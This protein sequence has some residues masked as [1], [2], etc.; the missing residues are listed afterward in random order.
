MTRLVVAELSRIAARRLVRLTVVLAIVGIALG[1]VA[2]FVWSDALPEQVYQQ[3]VVEAKARQVAE[4]A[5]I[6]RCLQAGAR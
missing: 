2:A 4:E 5:Q 3:R 6:E 1:G